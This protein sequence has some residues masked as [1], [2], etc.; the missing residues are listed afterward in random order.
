[1]CNHKKK[2]TRVHSVSHAAHRL[3]QHALQVVEMASSHNGAMEATGSACKRRWLEC[4]GPEEVGV[5]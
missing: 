5:Q 3:V 1:M 4:C 2:C